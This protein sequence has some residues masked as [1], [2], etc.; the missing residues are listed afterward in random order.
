MHAT[1]AFVG[2]IL[3]DVEEPTID[4]EDHGRYLDNAAQM[5]RLRKIW[6]QIDENPNYNDIK[7][8]VVE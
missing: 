1:W 6:T 8:V 7:P 4:V 5:T 3:E 2:H